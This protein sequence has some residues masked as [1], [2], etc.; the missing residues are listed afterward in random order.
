[1]VERSRRFGSTHTHTHT[2]TTEVSGCPF[3]LKS[4]D[5]QRGLGSCGSNSLSSDAQAAGPRTTLCIVGLGALYSFYGGK[6]G[7]WPRSAS[8]SRSNKT[9]T[10]TLFE[11]HGSSLTAVFVHLFID[12]T[13]EQKVLSCFS[14]KKHIIYIY[15]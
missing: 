1:M 5:V 4:V 2:C 7:P 12:L 14:F 10:V 8:Y 6:Q 11:A 15:I 3:Q 13:C 9:G